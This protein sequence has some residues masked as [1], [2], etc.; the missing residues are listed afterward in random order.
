MN[1][2]SLT[3]QDLVD[4]ALVFADMNAPA[5]IPKT[6]WL[7]NCPDTADRSGQLDITAA[8]ANLQPKT[9]C[10]SFNSTYNQIR[11]AL[12]Q[13]EIGTFF[14]GV[15]GVHAFDVTAFAEAT[16][17][18]PGIGSSPPFAATDGTAGGEVC[19]R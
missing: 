13:Q 2:P 7:D 3:L 16:V 6:D 18:L 4:Q 11:V 15:I 1:N 19:E 14:A 8:E 9:D 17:T 12:P 10:I 5:P